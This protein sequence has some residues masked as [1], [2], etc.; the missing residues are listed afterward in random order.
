MTEKE[1]TYIEQ[2]TIVTKHCF[3]GFIACEYHHKNLNIKVTY[4]P[5]QFLGGGVSLWVGKLHVNDEVIFK[6]KDHEQLLKK[7]CKEV[8]KK[9]NN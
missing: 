3:G 9:K 2:N 5:Y 8:L 4:H 6:A 7:Y 1:Q